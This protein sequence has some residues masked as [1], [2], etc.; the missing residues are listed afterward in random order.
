M[1]F[2]NYVVAL[3]VGSFTCATV[4]CHVAEQEAA[5]EVGETS[6]NQVGPQC[7]SYPQNP[8]CD[9][10]FFVENLWHNV[11]EDGFAGFV[12]PAAQATSC[13]AG[14]SAGAAIAFGAAGAPP[15]V[16]S[17]GAVAKALGT[18]VACKG[19]VEYL[20]RSG[21]ADNISCFFEPNLYDREVHLCECRNGCR[22][23]LRNSG[24]AGVGEE[25]KVYRYGYVTPGA[26]L[27][28]CTDDAKEVACGWH[29]ENGWRS[30]DR[31]DC[32]CR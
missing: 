24:T 32:T 21:V 26:A 7:G 22:S 12:V 1:R 6:S 11:Q 20:H 15:V 8:A 19:I 25:P 10:S 16:I 29:C 27:C 4:A 28:F 13:L 3:F 2:H 14:L 18:V 9:T 31:D 30:T 23:G 5:E 17:V